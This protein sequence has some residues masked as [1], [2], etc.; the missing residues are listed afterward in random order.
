M[1]QKASDTEAVM[2]H[3]ATLETDVAAA[4]AEVRRIFLETSQLVGERIKWNNPSFYYLGEMKD[5]DPKEYKR[6]MA[7]FNLFKN[8]IMLVFP[9]GGKLNNAAGVLT[10][11]YADGRRLIVFKDATEVK[12]NEAS[13]KSLLTEWISLVDK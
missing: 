1:Q 7:V 13:L 3:I 8:R 12:K 6:E 11:D 10:G 2:A 5:S 4:V 9:S